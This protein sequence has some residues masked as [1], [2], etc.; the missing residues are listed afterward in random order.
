MVV[1]SP[2]F[3][4]STLTVAYARERLIK[5]PKPALAGDRILRLRVM[6]IARCR[7]YLYM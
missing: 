7:Y 4:S 5:K 2:V 6:H 3:W 1:R